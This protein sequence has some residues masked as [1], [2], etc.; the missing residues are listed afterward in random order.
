MTMLTT[1][2]SGILSPEEVGELVV[3]PLQQRSVAL[4]TTTVVPMTTSAELRVPIVTEDVSASWTEEGQEIDLS[5][6]QVDSITIEPAKLAAI[7]P[8]SSE[9]A[10]DSSPEAT[11]LVMDSVTRDLQ[12]KLDSA[13]LGATVL[14]GPSGLLS[15]GDATPIPSGG[16]VNLDPFFAAQSEAEALGATITAWITSPA[17]AL[18]LAQLKVA[19]D[20]N[21]PLLVTG[22]DSTGKPQRVIGGVPLYVSRGCSAGV[23][24]GIDRSRVITALRRDVDVRV[25]DQVLF[26]SDRICVRATLR[27]SFGF[28]HGASVMRIGSGS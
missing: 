23:V 22:E 28:P 10:E 15:V 24:W 27:A 21:Q 11:R 6:S 26:T 9:L 7:T 5:E 8:V 19:T 4:Q 17:T 25:S 14:H 1:N 3:Q 2:A 12:L 20:W 16:F 18:Q 13:F